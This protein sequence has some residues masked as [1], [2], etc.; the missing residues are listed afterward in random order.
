MIVK[1]KDERAGGNR[2]EVAGDKAERQMAHYLDREFGSAPGVLVFNDLRL[3]LK[4]RDAV[5]IDHLIMH[6]H[7]MVIVESK[8]VTTK[9]KI[10]NHGEWMRWNGRWEGM[11]SP[12]EQARRQAEGLRGLLDEHRERLR[13]KKILGLV[14]GTFRCCPIDL[15]VAISDHGMF[16]EGS[17]RPAEAKKAEAVAGAVREIVERH[18]EAG[19]L[20]GMLTKPATDDGLYVLTT[21][22]MERV[23]EFL[24][25]RHSPRPGSRAGIRVA[26]PEPRAAAAPPITGTSQG[27]AHPAASAAGTGGMACR[28]CGGREGTARWGKYGYYLKCGACGKNTPL[29]KTCAGC[30]REVRIRKEG[31][32]FWRECA[33]ADGGGGAS[34]VVWENRGEA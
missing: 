30:G 29:E 2:F 24:L 5:Q 1:M 13:D 18:R 25:S 12:I 8:S 28:H 3:E 11:P 10:N 4:D 6:K 17:F 14:R 32:R 15:F 7:G 16:D 21:G 19:S 31:P 33:A 26:R 23:R 34:V 9:V 27:D 20:I 22:E